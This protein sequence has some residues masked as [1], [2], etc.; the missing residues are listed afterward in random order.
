[1]T[2]LVCR[3]STSTVALAPRLPMTRI[4]QA[5]SGVGVGAARAVTLIA[6]VLLLDTDVGV[7]ETTKFRLP[8]GAY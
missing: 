2:A 6:V 4:V 7:T 1:M 3:M 8:N 5:Y